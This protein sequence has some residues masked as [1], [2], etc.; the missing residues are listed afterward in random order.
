MRTGGY[1][2]LVSD[3]ISYDT[4]RTTISLHKSGD[5]FGIPTEFTANKQDFPDGID[6]EKVLMAFQKSYPRANISLDNIEIEA[7]NGQ[8]IVKIKS[9]DQNNNTNFPNTVDKFW[10]SPHRTTLSHCAAWDVFPHHNQ[11]LDVWTKAMKE[12][13]MRKGGILIHVDTHSDLVV[14]QRGEAIANFIN[15]ALLDGTFSEV[16]WVLPDWT[17]QRPST[18]WD[19]KK[20]KGDEDRLLG[21]REYVLYLDLR[22]GEISFS[23]PTDFDPN[24]TDFRTVKI[25]KVT[26]DELPQFTGRE[27]VSLDI[28]FDYFSNS[29]FDTAGDTPSNNRHNAGNDELLHDLHYFIEKIDERGIRPQIITLARSPNYTPSEDIP[30]IETFF[31]NMVLPWTPEYIF[32]TPRN[33]KHWHDRDVDYQNLVKLRDEAQ[34]LNPNINSMKDFGTIL[35]T[36]GFLGLGNLL[37]IFILYRSETNRQNLLREIERNFFTI[38]GTG[39]PRLEN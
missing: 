2:R 3:D 17:K 24:S 10:R 16:Y 28:D 13:K 23:K 6:K 38:T 25:H 4:G 31:R 39:V 7:L 12:G 27:N 29:G 20:E 30:V 9:P 11:S 34:N 15:K 35:T 36:R 1:V 14:G 8:Y 21:K 37:G 33:Y 18:Y 22:K 19:N 26:V 5:H 32:D